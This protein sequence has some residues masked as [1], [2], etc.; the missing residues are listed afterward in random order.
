VPYTI[1][2]DFGP[3]CL[4]HQL[5]GLAEGHK[6]GNVHGHNVT[7][8]VVLVSP[9]LDAHG[10][11]VDYGDLAPL[12]DWLWAEFDHCHLNGV[13]DFQPTA[14]NMARHI[15]E[16][17]VREFGWPVASVGWSETPATWALYTSAS[18]IGK[19]EETAEQKIERLMGFGVMDEETA[20]AIAEGRA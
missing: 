12:K 4:S 9:D 5:L 18:G 19:I 20:R 2:K 13:V 15:Y 17:A 6:C 10:F 8:R 11:V 16:H 3:L 14:E 7:V 1:T